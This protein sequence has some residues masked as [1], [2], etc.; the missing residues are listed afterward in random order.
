MKKLLIILLL[1]SSCTID[2][3]EPE[4]KP[5]NK[6]LTGKWI[7]KMD[8]VTQSEEN[9]TAVWTFKIV[10]YANTVTWTSSTYQLIGDQGYESNLSTYY[11]T[12]GNIDGNYVQLFFDNANTTD[13]LTYAWKGFVNKEYSSMEL[14]QFKRKG[15]G[16]TIYAENVIFIKQ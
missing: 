12:D 3:V 5:E 6:T 9:L 15:M 16:E 10:Q 1:F 7:G 11:L 13:S 14:D 4:V 2:E 8:V